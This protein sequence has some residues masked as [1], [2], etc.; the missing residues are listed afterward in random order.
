MLLHRLFH[1]WT[2]SYSTSQQ[3]WAAFTIALITHATNLLPAHN[4]KGKGSGIAIKYGG[5]NRGLRESSIG[6]IRGGVVTKW[7]K[8]MVGHRSLSV[9]HVRR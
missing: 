4:L 3:L 8:P 6:G 5:V 7:P 2:T 1:A 9:V